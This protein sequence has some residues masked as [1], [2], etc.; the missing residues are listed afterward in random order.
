MT[1]TFS[2]PWMIGKGVSVSAG[3]PAYC[4]VSP[5][6]VCLSVPQ[7]PDISMRSN[8]A[9]SSSRGRGNSCTS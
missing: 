7:I 6:Y 5:W 9:P 3:V 2:W 1:P 4:F 8:A